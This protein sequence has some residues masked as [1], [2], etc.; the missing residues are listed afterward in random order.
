MN[1]YITWG[2]SVIYSE[3]FV[4]GDVRLVALH[5]ILLKRDRGLCYVNPFGSRVAAACREFTDP[6]K[7][8]GAP[9]EA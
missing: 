5:G 9:P 2:E 6:S 7:S 1:I 4:A 8:L 3:N